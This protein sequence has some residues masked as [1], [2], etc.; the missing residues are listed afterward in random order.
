MRSMPHSPAGES[1]IHSLGGKSVMDEFIQLAVDN[2]GLSEDTA[3]TATGGLLQSI[4]NQVGGEA[5]RQLLLQ[6]PGSEDLIE[7]LA[8]EPTD[9]ESGGLISKMGTLFGGKVGAAT[10]LVGILDETGLEVD[11]IVPFASLFVYY[12]KSQ[13]ST[14]LVERILRRLPELQ[15]MLY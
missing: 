12:L 15:K 10:G 14:E 8:M 7:S 11:K 2:L 6:L 4:Q 1:R 9:G 5:A 3:R 13:V